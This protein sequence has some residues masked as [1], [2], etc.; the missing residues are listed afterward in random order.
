MGRPVAPSPGPGQPLPAARG[1]CASTSFLQP[2]RQHVR[3]DLRRRDVGMA[4]QQLQ[5]AQIGPAREHVAGERVPQHVRA[6]PRRIDPRRERRLFQHQREPLPRHRPRGSRPANSHGRPAVSPPPAPPP[7]RAPRRTAARSARVR[8]CPGSAAAPRRRPAPCAAG[9]QLGHPQPGRVEDLERR[10]QRQPLRRRPAAAAASSAST[11]ASLRYFGNGCRQA[12]RVEQLASDRLP[13]SPR[14]PGTGGTAASPTAAAPLSARR[15][16]PSRSAACSPAA[17][18]AR[19]APCIARCRKR[20]E[21]AEVGLDRPAACCAP[22][23]VRRPASPGTPR[24]AGPCERLVRLEAVVRQHALDLSRR[25]SGGNAPSTRTPTAEQA[26][27]RAAG[28]AKRRGAW[29]P[30]NFGGVC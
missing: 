5:A 27:S 6:D 1:W 4:Q 3:V 23:R 18:S 17:A 16:P 30:R 10:R 14:A 12:R 13:A 25:G 11:S 20:R 2:L 21:V 29:L 15:D 24:P 28:Q 22:R 8:P 7:P 26:D 9:Q 19:P